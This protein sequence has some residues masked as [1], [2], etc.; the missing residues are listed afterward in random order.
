MPEETQLDR[1][2]G[3]LD[4]LLEWVEGNGKPG[5]KSTL[6]WHGKVISAIVWFAGI[7]VVAGIGFGFWIIGQAMIA[8]TG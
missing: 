5:A 6:N 1:V 4:K 8:N 7:V 3:K 2:E